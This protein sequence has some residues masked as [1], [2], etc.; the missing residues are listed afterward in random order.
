[1]AIK[2]NADGRTATRQDTG[3][4]GGPTDSSSVTQKKA[5]LAQ[6]TPRVAKRSGNQPGL[7]AVDYDNGEILNKDGLVGVDPWFQHGDPVVP[8]EP[9]EGDGE[10][11]GE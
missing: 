4:R 2:K 7:G 5:P 6:S 8:T 10:T 1:M 9:D 11:G 3:T